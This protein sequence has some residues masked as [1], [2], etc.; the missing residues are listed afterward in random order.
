M[1]NCTTNQVARI[2][3]VRQVAAYMREMDP[4]TQL[5]EHAIRQLIRDGEINVI[6]VGNKF[7]LNLDQ[8]VERFAPKS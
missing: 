1:E 5:G 4:Q 7:L 2:R 6:K 8:I 3:T